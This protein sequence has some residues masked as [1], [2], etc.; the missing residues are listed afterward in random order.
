[1]NSP[2]GFVFDRPNGAWSPASIIKYRCERLKA[3]RFPR[4]KFPT[5]VPHPVFDYEANGPRSHFKRI[6]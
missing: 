1:M 2:W 3:S 6:R 5:A 4:Y